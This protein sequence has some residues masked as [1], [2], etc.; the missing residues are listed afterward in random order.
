MFFTP[1]QK[2]SAWSSP[3]VTKIKVRLFDLDLNAHLTNSRYLAFMYLGRL[4]LIRTLGLLKPMFKKGWM[5]VL[6]T[7][8]CSF[9]KEIPRRSLVELKTSIV[10]FNDKY[11]FIRQQFFVGDKLYAQALCR[12]L[13][14][15]KKKKVSPQEVIEYYQNNGQEEHVKSSVPN[16]IPSWEIFLKEFKD[17]AESKI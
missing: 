2:L 1:K 13:F 3:V 7:V 9:I 16:Y 17:S 6:S 5:P 14:T 12:G 15:C 11:W 8:N 10:G 4:D